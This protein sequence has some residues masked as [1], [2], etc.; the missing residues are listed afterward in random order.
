MNTNFAVGIYNIDGLSITYTTPA[1]LPKELVEQIIVDQSKETTEA[2]LKNV[3]SVNMPKIGTL[4][5]ALIGT[6]SYNAF[7]DL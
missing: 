7:S 3:M 4:P 6:Y 2:A 5:Q 1:S